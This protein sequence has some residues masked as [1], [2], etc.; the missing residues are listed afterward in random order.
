[1][2][3]QQRR[4]AEELLFAEEKKPS[5][6]K[7]LYF[8]QLNAEQ[9][10]PFP[11]VSADEKERTEAL[12]KQVEAFV[13]KEVDPS[14][15][16]RNAAIPDSVIAGLAKLG[17]FGVTVPT[18]WGGLGLS[19]Y[20]FCKMAAAIARKCGS[21]A[22]FLNVQQSIG[23]KA[24]LL[25]GNDAQREQWLKPLAKGEK[26]AAFALTEPN[27]GSDASGI[28][29]RAVYD[30]EK[31]VYRINGRKQWITNGSI[32][33]ALTVM[34]KTDDKITAFLVTPDMPGF[35]VTEASLEKVGTR[36]T[37][38][39]NLEFT[40]LEVPA[41]HI[42]GPVGGGLKVALTVLDYGRTTFGAM[43][44]GAAQEA[45]ALAI[46][47]AK[48][49]YQFKRPLASFALVKKKIALMSAL[50]YAMEATTF[51][52][53]GLIDSHVEDVMLES[54]MLKVFASD[55]LWTILYDV[56]QILGGRSF[57]TN[58]PYE[59]MMRDA[60]LNMIGEGSNEVMRA[61]IG[62]VGMR[63]VGMQFKSAFEALKQPWSDWETLKTF[64]FDR[65]SSLRSPQIPIHSSKLWEEADQLGK[66]IKRFGLA[67]ARLL[68]TYREEIVERQLLL[69]RVATSAMALYA[70]SSV[71]SRIDTA[72]AEKQK[73]PSQL[74]QELAIA[75]L[76]CRYA[77]EQIDNSLNGLFDNYDN[78]IETL[79]DRITGLRKL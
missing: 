42:L 79:S 33:H 76:Y 40:N 30:P 25:F 43:C 10:F 71:L 55:S 6:A 21:T 39:A 66:A 19:Q 26:F 35:K 36:G 74:D 11:R 70:I 57:F 1:M 2:D 77:F 28:E 4:L 58:A 62:A 18:Q 52:T 68:A 67:I 14:T 24:L 16:D 34:A 44:T 13:E 59:R 41:S 60:R 12:V 17:A 61:F 29:T 46:Q 3:E 45:V 23:L 7:K 47:H 8:G 27:A 64:A 54:A 9:I 72:L 73:E 32:A 38:T 56:M 75:K 63:D 78:A 49:R 5:F 51:M 15:I 37:K 20:A 48:T 31:K 50:L 69:D 22:L 65:L 53:A